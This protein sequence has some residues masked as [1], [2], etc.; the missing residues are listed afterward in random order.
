M[1]KKAESSSKEVFSRGKTILGVV[2]V[3]GI[4]YFA[5]MNHPTTAKV[6]V[7]SE[8]QRKEVALKTIEVSKNVFDKTIEICTNTIHFIGEKLSSVGKEQVKKSGK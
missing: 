5:G 7:E 2:L 3:F 8:P 1:A 6:Y 4:G